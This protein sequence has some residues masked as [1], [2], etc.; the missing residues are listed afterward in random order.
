MRGGDE[1]RWVGGG[2]GKGSCRNLP[3]VGFPGCG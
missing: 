1:V 2:D 3:G